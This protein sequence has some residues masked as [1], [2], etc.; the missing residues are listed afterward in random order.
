MVGQGVLENVCLSGRIVCK[1]AKGL[2]TKIIN[3]LGTQIT[4]SGHPLLFQHQLHHLPGP[5]F[6]NL[7]VSDWEFEGSK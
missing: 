6:E 4:F 5:S 1:Y 7:P 2:C 3:S